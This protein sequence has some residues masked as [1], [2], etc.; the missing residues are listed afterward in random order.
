MPTRKEKFNP[1]H[2]GLIYYGPHFCP[3]GCGKMI[4]MTARE[5]GEHIFDAPESIIYPNTLWP[6]HEC[7]I[8]VENRANPRMI[9]GE[10]IR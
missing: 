9:H 6:R 7:S 4:V 5:Q 10:P 3:H 2:K 8:P 1:R